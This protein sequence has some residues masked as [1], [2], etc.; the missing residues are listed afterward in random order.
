MKCEKG[1]IRLH[2]ETAWRGPMVTYR[3]WERGRAAWPVSS[4]SSLSCYSALHCPCLPPQ[5][6]CSSSHQHM[7][8][9]RARIAQTALPK[10][11]TQRM[12]YY[13]A[14]VTKTDKNFLVKNFGW[15][16]WRFS[17]TFWRSYN[18]LSCIIT[19][20]QHIKIFP[21]LASLVLPI[22]SF[23]EIF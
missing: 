15:G 13:I 1:Q 12:I 17:N 4:Y 21:T 11:P 2:G 6:W 18:E 7:R 19:Q 14:T 9:C 10:L 3:N 16:Y 22:F 8:N 20:I 5:F 23:A